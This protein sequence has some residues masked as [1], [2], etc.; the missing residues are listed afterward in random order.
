MRASVLSYFIGAFFGVEVCRVVFLSSAY[1][2]RG[3]KILLDSM[4]N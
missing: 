4:D 2:A 3:N 1:L